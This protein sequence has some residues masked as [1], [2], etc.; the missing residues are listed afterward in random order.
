MKQPKKLTRNQKEILSK[1][2]Y[3]WTK[4]MFDSEDAM[5]MYFVEKTTNETVALIKED[6]YDVI[7]RNTHWIC[8]RRNF[9]CGYYVYTT[10]K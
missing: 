2:G 1:K 9:R 8:N 5:C 4:Y 3:D 10:N 6:I 7:W